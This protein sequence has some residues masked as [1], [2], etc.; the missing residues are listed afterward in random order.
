MPT[1]HDSFSECSSGCS[2][3]DTFERNRE[4]SPSAGESTKSLVSVASS[5]SESS[6][7][8]DD[9]Y[10]E[11]FDAVESRRRQADAHE[12]VTPLK[13]F[14]VASPQ[15]RSPFDRILDFFQIDDNSSLHSTSLSQSPSEYVKPPSSDTK[16]PAEHAKHPWGTQRHH[17]KGPG[18]HAETWDARDDPSTR[19]ES[20]SE[21]RTINPKTEGGLRSILLPS[22]ITK[23]SDAPWDGDDRDT[24]N[25]RFPFDDSL[26][27]ADS[28]A[29]FS[30]SWR[31]V[32]W[33]R[34][35]SAS[36]A[37]PSHSKRTAESISLPTTKPASPSPEKRRVHFKFEAMHE[38]DVTW[39][40]TNQKGYNVEPI[41]QGA[42]E[43]CS[44]MGGSP[45]ANL[46][47]ILDVTGN[48]L[49]EDPSTI[50]SSRMLFEDP[51]EST[52]RFDPT[53]G[54]P[55]ES[56]ARVAK[57]Q[58]EHRP[59]ARDT[60]SHSERVKQRR[61]GRSM[62]TKE[63]VLAQFRKKPKKALAFEKS[64]AKKDM[65]NQHSTSFPANLDNPTN[66]STAP[67]SSSS[68]DESLDSVRSSSVPLHDLCTKAKTSGDRSWGDAAILLSRQPH[69]AMTLENGWTPLHVSCL[70]TF[71]PA[72]FFVRALLMA[73]P[74]ATQVLDNGGRL[75]LHLLAATSA[76]PDIMQMLVDEYPCAI[77]EY[78]D[79][80]MLPL[81]RLIK[82]DSIHLTLHQ[83][84]I[85]LGQT[86]KVAHNGRN[87]R[88]SRRRGEHLNLSFQE[89]NELV[90]RDEQQ[91]GRVGNIHAEEIQES[92]RRLSRWKAKRN[93]NDGV[94]ATTTDSRLLSSLNPAALPSSSSGQLALHMAASRNF[95]SSNSDDGITSSLDL[96]KG[97]IAVCGRTEILRVLI[98]ANPA[99]LIGRDSNG[100]TP[101]L[102]AMCC[103]DFLPDRDTVELL[104]GRNTAGFESPPRWVENMEFH[105][106]Q[107]S[108]FSNPA[109]IITNDMHQTPLHIAAEQMTS[110]IGVLAA[111][112]EAYPGAVHVQDVR[113][114]T[115]LHLAL[116]NFQSLALDPKAFA[117]LLTDRVAQTKDDEGMTPLDRFVEH[118]DRL[119]PVKPESHTCDT[120]PEDV[121]KLF[122]QESFVPNAL[123]SGNDSA[124]LLR[125][126]RKFPR[127]LRRLAL[128]SGFVQ[129][130][131]H[132]NTIQPPQVALILLHGAVLGAFLTLFRVQLD[133]FS[134]AHESLTY[135]AGIY[136]LAFLMFLYQLLYCCASG[137]VS[138]FIPESLLSLTFWIDV[139]GVSL[140]VA[141][142][143]F[144][145]INEFDV[146]ST[147]G[148]VATGLLWMSV[149]GYIARWWYGMAIFVGGAARLG[150]MLLWP[151]IAGAI[152]VVGFAQMLLTLNLTNRVD[153]C[154]SAL[155]ER[156]LCNVHDAYMTVYLLLLGTPILFTGDAGDDL[157]SGTFA[158]IATFTVV[159][160]LFVFNLII[161]MVQEASRKDWIEVAVADFWESKL[162]FLYLTTD[163]EASF[164]TCS[165]STSLYATR[166]CTLTCD[167]NMNDNLAWFWDVC[168][169]S[170]FSE[171][172]T[173]SPGGGSHVRLHSGPYQFFRRMAAL[174]LVPVW[175]VLGG[176]TLGL[177][178][179]PQVRTWLFR[180]PKSSHGVS[181]FSSLAAAR[182]YAALREDLLQLKTMS[183]E[184]ANSIEQ[185]VWELRQ[186]ILGAVKDERYNS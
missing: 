183:F 89:V 22:R 47:K 111:I 118:L 161:M 5:A 104:L 44:S 128:S 120:S 92:L 74:E 46:P 113:G 154:E 72:D 48:A 27:S 163:I 171:Y 29:N 136:S 179:P 103:Q 10:D 85:L 37:P 28:S 88:V 165:S 64:T 78:D 31:K 143:I 77:T 76:D 91:S 93:G 54:S 186:I 35:A 1:V 166:P 131:I 142:T 181:T 70:G 144:M 58:S 82:N 94:A 125:R 21:T 133:Q 73:A 83:V 52:H 141:A 50:A 185:H 169:W 96:D 149:I 129:D 148:T 150:R 99:A 124:L 177:L 95:L 59:M 106:A 162:I 151:L 13:S 115:P 20:P 42:E 105:K 135:S 66:V 140:A 40:S 19:D 172:S 126:L 110:N 11:D 117:L 182:N 157:T 41:H 87:E 100:R 139:A 97:R 109:M 175:I 145:E 121:Y 38:D 3:F 33:P 23:D 65:T 4:L 174:A 12:N 107:D 130:K 51:P 81:H 101:L 114:R 98:A 30:P 156:A 138:P 86:I 134:R 71:A 90:Y 17:D 168:I 45:L 2:S 153:D 146:V 67:S 102:V 164:F 68:L 79:K 123:F 8:V 6:I 18:D 55:F 57:V 173:R 14:F 16:P 9:E 69:L 122:F 60:P 32:T 26:D 75:P 15:N 178:W 49:L 158:L 56:E 80:G 61:L 152:L 167:K 43:T 53:T 25:S 147:L 63:D 112:Y 108:R 159:L 160:V 36:L 155:G 7:L 170:I 39:K 127:W 119:S 116:D 24:D 184:K 137:R 132:E 180:I 34:Y 84:R 62:K 176:I